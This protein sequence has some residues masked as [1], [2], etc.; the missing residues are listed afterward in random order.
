MATRGSGRIVLHVAALLFDRELRW[1]SAGI[2]REL[3]AAWLP[4][5]ARALA[6]KRA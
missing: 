5:R 3:A 4:I 6:A 1:H 2:A